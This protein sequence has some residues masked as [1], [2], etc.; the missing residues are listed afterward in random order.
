MQKIN[1]KPG[2]RPGKP[3]V[4]SSSNIFNNDDK[5]REYTDELL[6]W[7]EKAQE[8]ETCFNKMA[9]DNEKIIK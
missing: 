2:E 5:F 8:M 4:G 3:K 9:E 6:M 7:K 1:L